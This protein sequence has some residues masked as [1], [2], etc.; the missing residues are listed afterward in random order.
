MDVVDS[1]SRGSTVRTCASILEYTYVGLPVDPVLNLTVI[2][3]PFET[4]KW[5]LYLE[6]VF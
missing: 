3:K 5:A 1:P 2:A 4:S 6:L